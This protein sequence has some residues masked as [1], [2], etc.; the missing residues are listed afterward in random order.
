MPPIRRHSNGFLHHA[1]AGPA[2]TA[3]PAA[4]FPP[5]DQLSPSLEVTTYSVPVSGSYS[6]TSCSMP[7]AELP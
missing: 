4:F 5:V 6:N 2:M 7:P 1:E 3:E